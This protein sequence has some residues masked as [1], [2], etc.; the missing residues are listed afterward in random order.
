MKKLSLNLMAIVLCILII[1]IAIPKNTYASSV[2]SA[3]TNLT[4]TV[5]NTNQIYLTWNSV[6]YS[7][8][9]FIYRATSPSGAYS[10]IASPTNTTYIDTNLSQ[11]TTYYYK[12]KAANSAGSSSYSP[13][14]YAKTNES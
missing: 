3:P 5:A 9:Y 8:G 10:I 12:V 2:P 11:N 4:A 14:V 7:T 6:S 1:T 13:I